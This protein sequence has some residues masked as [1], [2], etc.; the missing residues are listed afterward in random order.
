LD[1]N[2]GCPVYKVTKTGAGSAWLK[3]P[4]ELYTYM[5]AFVMASHKPVSAK[6]RLGWDEKSINFKEVAIPFG[7]A[8]ISL[9]TIHARTSKQHV[10]GRSQLRSL[11][12]FGKSLSIPFASRATSSPPKSDGSDEKT[13]FFG[14]GGPGRLRQSAS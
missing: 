6:I 8:G 2:L 12:D 3:H 5:R 9:L 1:I 14:H 4:E 11:K 10:Y 7:E 13:G